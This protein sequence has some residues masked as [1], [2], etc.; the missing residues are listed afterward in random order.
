M[1]LDIGVGAH[2]GSYGY[3]GYGFFGGHEVEG[4]PHGANRRP[5]IAG[6]PSFFVG[7]V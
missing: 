5:Y 7:D 3:T 1:P 2:E 4:C 6:K